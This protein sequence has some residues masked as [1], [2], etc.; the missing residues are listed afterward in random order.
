MACNPLFHAVSDLIPRQA[1]YFFG[2]G[3]INDLEITQALAVMLG[4]AW[5]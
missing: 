3:R 2:I 5:R 4:S 1:R